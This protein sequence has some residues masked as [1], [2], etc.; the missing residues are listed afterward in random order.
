MSIAA[1]D[2][3]IFMVQCQQRV[4]ISLALHLAALPDL[5]PNLR[6]AMEY[7]C[8][9]GG[10]RVRPVLAYATAQAFGAALASADTAACA[11]EMIHCYSLVHDD[12]PA[13][14]DDD[15][16]RGKPTVHVAFNE[17]TA[18]LA[19]DALQ[20]LA[21]RLLSDPDGLPINDSTRLRMI[22]VLSRAAGYE[23][24]VGGQSIDFDA[25]G[26]TLELEQMQTMHSLKTGALINASVQLGALSTELAS[27]EQ[28]LVLRQYATC[29]G[30]AFQVK[31]DILDVVSDTATLGKKQGADQAHNKPT[32]VSLL[33][34]DGARNKAE[35][36]VCEAIEALAE[37]DSKADALRQ[38]ARYIVERKN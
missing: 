28:L 23:G 6:T 7:A 5:T 25:V 27:P 8:L 35:A 2:L 20:G 26:K 34:L 16:R 30:L 33:G 19:G 14:D 9:Q 13:M 32:Y 36:L 37:F 4:Q 12:L 3:N 29:V 21:F 22:N 1:F 31:D 24:M 15:L 18:I 38:I 17:A 10:K 11:L